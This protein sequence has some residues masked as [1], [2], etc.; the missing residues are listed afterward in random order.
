M[1]GMRKWEWNDNCILHGYPKISFKNKFKRDFKK[2]KN[3]KRK[4]KEQKR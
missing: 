3:E 2:L 4:R 1:S